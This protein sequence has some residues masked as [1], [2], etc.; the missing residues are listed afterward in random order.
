MRLI[1]DVQ[2]AI[3][4][5][6]PEE[7]EIEL[8]NYLEDVISDVLGPLNVDPFM[9]WMKALKSEDIESMFKVSRSV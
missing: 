3:R 4:G 8:A 1:D 6:L 2:S 9:R 7:W 5:F